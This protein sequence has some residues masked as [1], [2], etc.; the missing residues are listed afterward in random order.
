MDPDTDVYQTEQPQISY[1]FDFTAEQSRAIQSPNL[2]GRESG[3]YPVSTKHQKCEVWL[4][5]KAIG[6]LGV[7]DK[8]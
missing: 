3:G 6:T 8:L 2:L 5:H 7:K 1:S 4:F